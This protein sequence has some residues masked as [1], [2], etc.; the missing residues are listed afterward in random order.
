[1][2]YKKEFFGTIAICATLIGGYYAYSAWSSSSAQAKLAQEVKK[3]D[4]VLGAQAV[5][6]LQGMRELWNSGIS[7][8][9]I[10][11]AM[12]ARM[13]KVMD[14]YFK[15]PE[16]P[17]RTKY[18]DQQIDIYQ[19]M[20]AQRPTT[21]PDRPRGDRPEG[22]RPAGDRPTTGPTEEQRNEWRARREAARENMPPAV[23]AQRAEFIGAV[24]ARAKERGITVRP[25]FGGGGGR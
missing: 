18:L 16:G 5:P 9:A 11:Q 8:N 10:G 20:M 24:M 7:R 12:E 3:V 22:D 2:E 15:I 6:N 14:D 13:Q 25:P 17:A 21:R 19:K 1:M 23:R 4:E